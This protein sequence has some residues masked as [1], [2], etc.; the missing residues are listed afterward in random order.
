MLPTPIRVPDG[1]VI[2]LSDELRR[3]LPEEN[4]FDYLLTIEGEEFRAV[5]NRRTVRFSAGPKYYFIKIHRGCGWGEILKNLIQFKSPV[6]GAEPERKGIVA[7]TQI[8]VPTA[9]LAG[10][11]SRGR[12]PARRESFVITES[13]DGM[14]S[15]AVL[16]EQHWAALPHR[17]R[18][19]LKRF[20]LQRCAEI[21]RA[22]H[23]HGMN[24]RDFYLYHFLVRERDWTAW[25]PSDE[26]VVFLIDLHR[27]QFR[28]RVHERWLVKDLGGL[29]FAALDAGLT[30]RDLLRFAR[31]YHAAPLRALFAERSA[32]WNRVVRNA[33][34]LYSGF[35]RRPPT[36]PPA[37]L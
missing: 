26:T 1:A 29:L 11:G 9:T 14:V 33:C 12:N 35:H 2:E 4:A 28:R 32:L 16:L 3:S 23:T 25:D 8:G 19:R 34:K 21:A 27:M 31:T 10:F 5:K 13:L 18:L 15:L 17:Q 36:L 6:T 22:L 20:F 7:L 37:L 24:H 30:T